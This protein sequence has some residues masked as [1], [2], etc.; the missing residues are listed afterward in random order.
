M[1]GQLSPVDVG[2]VVLYILGT[3]ALGA[4]F[5]RGQRDVRTYFVGDRN[6]SW[7]LVLASIVATETSTVTFLSVPGFAYKDG[8]NFTFLQLCF[9]YLLGRS[10]IAWFLLPQYFRGEL[11]SAYELLR[12]TF[13]PA[14]QRAASGLFIITRTIADGLRLFLTAL[15][16]QQF[17]G[18][19][20]ETSILVMGVATILYTYL[21]GMQ[22]VIWTDLIQFIIYI[23]GAGLALLVMLN[24]IG[25]ATGTAATLTTHAP[26]RFRL[27]DFSLTWTNAYSFWAGLFGGAAFTMATHGADQLT[28][29][30][31]LCARSLGA[32]RLA[33][34]SSG[35]VVFA[36]FALF[37][38]I[39]VGLFVLK[40]LGIM[41]VAAGTP[42]DQVFGLFIVSFLP[43]G[44]IGLVVAAVLAAAMSTLSSSLNSSANAL[45][46]DFYRPLNPVRS[47]THYLA[48]SRLLT[49]GFGVLQMGVAVGAYR[50]QSDQLVVEQV[51]SVAGLTT[52]LVLGLFV[53]G[54]LQRPVP[55]WAALAGFVC[56]AIAV[57]AVFRPAQPLLD[58]MPDWVPGFFRRPIL[59]WPWYAPV[60]T[61]TT[62]IVA[63]LLTALSRRT[64]VENGR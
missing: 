51:L 4:W 40:D 50:L 58:Q 64:A 24:L 25:D 57:L 7:W 31:Y 53:L 42:N 20:F 5:S 45:V 11:F 8:G 26:E 55:S 46:T 14:V 43:V 56:G 39:G 44:V 41:R 33:L 16:L 13:G 9:G 30:R 3:T 48:V 60:G 63:L 37:L 23:L 19:P 15:L 29:Q 12:R 47:D 27:F 18:W 21:G 54:I 32:A 52:G 2:V 38:F 28:V 61:G 17:T 6:V 35:F 62:V 1:N 36:Q 59:A 49:A 34:M 22:A 10:L